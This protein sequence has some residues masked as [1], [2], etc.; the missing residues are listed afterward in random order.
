[1]KNV[2]II[3]VF[4]FL[5]FGFLIS[6]SCQSNLNKQDSTIM[7][8]TKQDSVFK[9]W[10][11]DTMEV[12]KKTPD[13]LGDGLLDVRFVMT[14]DSLS[15]DE[16]KKYSYKSSNKAVKSMILNVISLLKEYS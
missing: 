16:F 8:L 9:R 11:R 2:K 10:V 7:K 14:D 6:V 4:S 12:I 1:M 3:L 15:L 13:K 5:I